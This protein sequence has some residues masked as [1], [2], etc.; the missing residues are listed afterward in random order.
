V[1][2]FIK[3]HGVLES[4]PGMGSY[5]AAAVSRGSY[6]DVTVA[7]VV[8]VV[9][10][11]GTNFFFF[12]P[13]VAWAD[14]FRLETSESADKPNSF[15]LNVL[16]RSSVP[17]L[18]GYATHPIGLALDGITRPFG[19]A[20]YPLHGDVRRRRVGDIIFWTV[21]G[22]AAVVV[23]VLGLIYLNSRLGFTHLPRLFAM[24]FA[25]FG[26]VVVL[27]VISSIIWVP[28]GV[29]IGMS[30]KLSRYAQPVVQILA[31]FPAILLF[32]FATLI[33]I[34][35]GIPLDLGAIV[36]MMLGAQWYILFNVIAGAS[37]IPNDLREMMVVTRMP[38]SQR[39]RQVILPAI[40]PAYVT[41]GITAAGGAW[42][43]S[44]VAELVAWHHHTLHAYGLGNSIANSSNNGDFALLI[45]GGIVMSAFVVA[46]NRLFWRRLYRLAESRYTL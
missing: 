42:N 4:L 17:G 14:K 43:A 9:L 35:L 34:D 45:A 21:V 36:L 18:A 30:A 1:T 6:G 24:G 26:R 19:L 5:M 29:K 23:V 32:P 38:R 20:E 44:I 15:V 22:G 28:V 27:L 46:A 31:S 7:I 41:G 39:W 13:L 10:V 2:V 33:F 25:T 12:R 8:M 3:G 37:A 11:V 40:F 16:R